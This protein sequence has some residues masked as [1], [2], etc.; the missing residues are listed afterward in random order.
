MKPNQPKIKITAARLEKIKNYLFTENSDLS[1][2]PSDLLEQEKEEIN[3][4]KN[5][6]KYYL[7][8][9]EK[10]K[11]K[12]NE[13]QKKCDEHKNQL[14]LIQ[15]QIDSKKSQLSSLEQQKYK[16]EGE[17]D[18]KD[19]NEDKIEKLQ[20]EIKKIIEKIEDVENQ[21]KDLEETQ[22][23]Y[24]ELLY[25]VAGSENFKKMLEEQ[26]ND[27]QSEY[28]NDILNSLNNLYDIV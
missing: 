26:Y 10:D 24:Q 28:K 7:E 12:I 21:I 5:S 25:G 8:L 13:E 9:L 23:K 18:R 19:N 11:N 4:L 6:Y 22:E 2:L 1:Y 27:S 16:K 14:A 15:L 20:D 17:I 3:K